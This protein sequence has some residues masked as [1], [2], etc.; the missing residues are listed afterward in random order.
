MIFCGELESGKYTQRNYSEPGRGDMTCFW[1]VGTGW[2][3]YIKRK[4][5]VTIEISDGFLRLSSVTLDV[6]DT[7]SSVVIDGKPIDFIRDGKKHR[8]QRSG[9]Q[10]KHYIQMNCQEK[11]NR[12]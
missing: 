7:V 5:E 6:A 3:N 12:L 11:C 9:S 10:G 1:S 4:N 2:G 8:F